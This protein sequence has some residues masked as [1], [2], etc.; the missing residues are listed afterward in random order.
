MINNESTILYTTRAYGEE[1]SY[2]VTVIAKNLGTEKCPF[3]TLEEVCNHVFSLTNLHWQT[4]VPGLVK[5][6]ITLEF[7]KAIAQLSSYEIKPKE[8]SWL[9][10]TLWFI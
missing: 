5:L 3:K 1:M 4:V 6:P 2:P 7:A 10:R 9:W 8:D